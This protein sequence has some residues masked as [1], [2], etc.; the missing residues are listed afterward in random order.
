LS[1]AKLRPFPGFVILNLFQDPL[2]GF[3]QRIEYELR[4]GGLP[5]VT[6]RYWLDDPETG[7]G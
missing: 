4:T 7:S 2:R 6:L 5:M 1:V 3:T